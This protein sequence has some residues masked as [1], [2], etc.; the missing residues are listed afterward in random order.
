MNDQVYIDKYICI[1]DWTVGLEVELKVLWN[2]NWME[3]NRYQ[4]WTENW[5]WKENGNSKSNGKG[6]SNGNNSGNGK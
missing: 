2:Y 3:R 6:S 1:Y 5:N 4:K